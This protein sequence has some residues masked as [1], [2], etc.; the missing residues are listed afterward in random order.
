VT[1][2]LHLPVRRARAKLRY[3]SDAVEAR[4]VER[5][6]GFAL[7]LD[8]PVHGVAPGQVAALYDGDAVVG[9]GIVGAA[10]G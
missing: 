4:V 3:R 6:G 1:G 8:T 10:G 9:A 2:T 5:P 7:E